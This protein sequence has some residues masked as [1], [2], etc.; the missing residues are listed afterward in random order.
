MKLCKNCKNKNENGTCD[1][2]YEDVI[3]GDM[4]EISFYVARHSEVFCGA[5]AK[6]Y[7]E[8]EK[9]KEEYE[10]FIL[11]DS[12]GRTLRIGYEKD[13]VFNLVGAIYDDACC[14]LSTMKR[15]DSYRVWL[16][17]GANVA[18]ADT[19]PFR[20]KYYHISE[21]G[22]FGLISEDDVLELISGDGVLGLTSESAGNGIYDFT[23]ATAIKGCVDD[24]LDRYSNGSVVLF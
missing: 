10:L 20:E 18:V 13:G 21:D 19:V 2:K 24:N 6:H 1:V 3:D 4:S 17:H 5:S 22:V 9:G 14:F 12:D 7:D 11:V 15:R 23:N 8:K 16:N